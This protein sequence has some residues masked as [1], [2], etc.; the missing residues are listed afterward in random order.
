MYSDNPDLTI[1]TKDAV[2]IFIECAS[3]SDGQSCLSDYVNKDA[4]LNRAC[5][6]FC[7]L[8]AMSAMEQEGLTSYIY[9]S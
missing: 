2:T 6:D 9:H 4:R 7:D 3:S 1:F 8:V 5:D